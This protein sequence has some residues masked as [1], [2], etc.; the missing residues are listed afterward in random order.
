L[1]FPVVQI[2]KE[3]KVDEQTPVKLSVEL[4]KSGVAFLSE[5]VPGVRYL[6][7]SMSVDAKIAGTIAKP[8]MSG[9]AQIDLPALRFRSAD[10]PAINSFRGNLAF[11][12]D[13]LTIHQFS[14]DISGGPVNLT[15][16]I[17][18]LKLT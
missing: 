3:R 6:E 2:L 18:F 7:G 10:A 4:P 12:G 9:A 1:P 8:E 5:V 15:G 13:K 16:K 11:E 17:Q 14:G